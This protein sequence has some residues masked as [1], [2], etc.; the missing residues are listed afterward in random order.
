MIAIAKT[1]I[2]L[3]LI[4]LSLSITAQEL[5]FQFG[6]GKEIIK[7]DMTWRYHSGDDT[8]WA[9]PSFNDSQWDTINPSLYSHESEGYNGIAWF[10]QTIDLKDSLKNKS[11][12]L[13]IEHFGASEIYI[14]GKKVKEFGTVSSKQKEEIAYKPQGEPF[15]FILNRGGEH[16]IAVRYSNQRAEHNLKTFGEELAGF[17]F[18]IYQS[19]DAI[20]GF[21]DKLLLITLPLALGVGFF[22]ALGLLHIAIFLFYRNER[23][24]LYYSLF[25]STLA[26]YFLILLISHHLNFPYYISLLSLFSEMLGPFQSLSLLALV[27]SFTYSTFPKRFWIA[28]AFGALSIILFFINVTLA[29]NF[30]RILGLL[31]FIDTFRVI[32]LSFLKKYVP[33]RKKLKKRSKYFLLILVLVSIFGGLINIMIPVLILCILLAVII[34]PL[35]GSIFIVPI[36]MSI[37]H[38]RSFSATNKNLIEQL[39]N[40]TELSAKTIEQERERQRIIEAQKE[41]LEVQVAE[42]TLELSQKNIEITDSI[43]YAKRIQSAILPP[44]E[45]IKSAFPQS[46]VLFKPKDIVSGDFYWFINNEDGYLIAAADC[47]GHGVPGAFMSVLSSEKLSLAAQQ[48]SH[49][50]EILQKAN[51]GIK[52]SLR[53]SDSQDSTRDGMDVSLCAFNKDLSQLEYAG[54]NRPLWIIRKDQLEIEEIKATKVAIGGL[55]EDT[56]EFVKHTIDLQKGDSVYLF[57]DGYADQFSPQ[58]KKLMTRKFK[59]IILSIQNKTMEEQKEYL[60]SFIDEWKGN[61]EQTDDIL[62]IGVRG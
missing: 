30:S 32:I 36:Y 7:M 23:S 42:R 34:L 54:A 13:V 14:N 21:T 40:V 46:F 18:G 38:A 20:R 16:F 1:F 47:T 49:V 8:A 53:Q 2:S 57:S 39:R 41:H 50:S 28:F 5:D 26:L 37:H 55:T 19:E 60:G 11:L 17:T 45:N 12:A 56:Q 61:M 44:I 27:Y 15:T 58:D 10:R 33:D 22:F 31:C 4:I 24:N 52:K 51:V 6:T 59:E 3:I 25:T 43:N 29:I 62:V 9:N 35:V 48:S